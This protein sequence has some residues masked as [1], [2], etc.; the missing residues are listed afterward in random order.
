MSV[1]F[2]KQELKAIVRR[3]KGIFLTSFLLIFF[4]CVI[5]AISLPSVYQSTVMIIVENQEIPEEYVK[6]TMT[7]YV[8]ERLEMLRRKILS[9]SKLLKIAKEHNLY[10]D[11]ALDGEIVQEMR[12]DI[13]L[14]TIDVSLSDRKSRVNSSATIAF[15]LSYEHKNPQKAK[16]I[17]DVLANLFIEEDQRSRESQAATTTGFIE[18]ELEDLRRQ[19]QI[20]EEKISRFKAANI[21]Q[22]PGSMAIFTQTIF[23]LEQDIDSV[24]A[25]IRTTQDKI[26]Y[27]KSQIANIDPLVPILTETGK[28][29][30]NPN[31][32]LKY[33]RLQLLSMQAN[34]SDKHPDIIK[35]KSEIQ[36]LEA[37]AGETGSS[38]EKIN[39]LR[40][41]EKEIIELKSK[42]GDKHPDVVRLSKEADLL[43]QQIGQSEAGAEK[44]AVLDEQT[45]NP[46]YMNIKA[47]IIVAESEVNALKNER[48]K[49]VEKLDD[50]QK[51]LETAPFIDE[52]YNKLT[53]DYENARRKFNEASNKLH[54]AKISQEMDVSDQGQRFH[55]DAKAFLP[56]KPFKP[57]RLIIILLG[58]LLGLG[59]AVGLTAVKEGMDTSIKSTDEAESIFGVPVLATVAF[60]DTP[61]QKR[62]R[63]SKRLIMVFT[64]L[65]ITIAASLM[66]NWF[67]APIGELLDIF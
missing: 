63:R 5:V 24:E 13:L 48:I 33:L 16:E 23:R 27:L 29:A 6:S 41:V 53:L 66:V 30:S 4:T 39:R 26:V 2:S 35:L 28:V 67:V 37:Q 61:T 49:L 55:I 58:F 7:S 18:K 19:V 62:L 1:E 54:D 11:L 60:F 34:L 9:H 45:D 46:G 47:Q 51:R 38:V 42:Y 32:R 56:D 36:E 65:V 17:T 15:N 10:P 59:V 8:S 57:N 31:N 40:V 22:L 50:Y 21:D 43:R 64:L 3:R 25:R 14:E 12:K 20:N 44:A 52:E